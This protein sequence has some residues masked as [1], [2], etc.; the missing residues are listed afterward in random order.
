MKTNLKAILIVIITLVGLTI[1]GKITGVFNI[2][3]TTNLS[4]VKSVT[5]T[6]QIQTPQQRILGTWVMENSPSDKIEFLANG[7]VKR[8]YDGNMLLYTGTYSISNQCEGVVSENESL[9]LRIVD[10]EDGTVE[11][12]SILSGVYIDNTDTLTI[13]TEGQGKIIVYHRI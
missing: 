5:P 1:Y 2:Q 6:Q 7:Q 3:K 13:L 11:C 9:Y 10:G 12:Q 8:Y 4:K